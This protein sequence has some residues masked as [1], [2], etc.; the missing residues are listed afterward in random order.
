MRN[1]RLTK[2]G[3]ECAN[4]TSTVYLDPKKIQ[5]EGVHFVSHAH[6]DHLPNGGDGTILCST[7]TNKIAELRGFALKNSISTLENFTLVDSGHIFGSK[8]LLFDD[9]FYTGDISTRD[10]GFLNGAK[11]PKCKTLITECTFGLPEFVLPPV[12]EIVKQVNEIIANLYSKGKP[13]LLLGYE[14]GKAQT[15]SQLFRDWDPIYYHDSVKR[16]NDLHRSKGVPLKDS[17]GHTEAESKGLLDKNP[18]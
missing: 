2:N 15:L 13:V 16:M 10:R 14:L 11:I 12:I 4:S 5:N 17:L 8:G 1:I 9:I 18:W 6:I 3:I 7:E